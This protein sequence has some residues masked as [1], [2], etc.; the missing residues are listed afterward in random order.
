M[1]KCASLNSLTHYN[2][3]VRISLRMAML[4]ISPNMDRIGLQ[5]RPHSLILVCFLA[6]SNEQEQSMLCYPVKLGDSKSERFHGRRFSTCV[7]IGK[8]GA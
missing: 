3:H 1:I 8:N 5:D 7:R 6:V 2:V 4:E